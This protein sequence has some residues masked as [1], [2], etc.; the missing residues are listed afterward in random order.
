[1]TPAEVAF[2]VRKGV[3]KRVY[4]GPGSTPMSFDLIISMPRSALRTGSES[5]SDGDS[6]TFDM[7][8]LFEYDEEGETGI[9][10]DGNA[11]PAHP[12][13]ASKP[14]APIDDGAELQHQLS[15]TPRTSRI[16]EDTVAKPVQAKPSNKRSAPVDDYMTPQRKRVAAPQISTIQESTVREP[17]QP[18][19][20]NRRSTPTNNTATPHHQ[21]G[22]APHTTSVVVQSA[23][24]GVHLDIGESYQHINNIS[25]IPVQIEHLKACSMVVM[26][27]AAGRYWIMECPWCAANADRNSVYFS[28]MMKLYDHMKQNH[29]FFY[30][31][32]QFGKAPG[33]R[34]D[35]C[36]KRNISLEEVRE[37]QEGVQVV[38]VKRHRANV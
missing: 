5:G 23:A 21:H 27:R 11:E 2:A 16:G 20:I 34:F 30:Q 28:S 22:A 9:Q 17:A 10:G 13:Q 19:Q 24:G 26:D 4:Q 14:S 3:E 36:K 8:D 15:P 25:G 1:M 35:L 37:I 18:G 12:K 6:E 38:E 33:P 32:L 7:G 31:Q 29:K